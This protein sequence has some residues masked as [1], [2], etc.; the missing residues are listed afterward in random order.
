M[1]P[2]SSNLSRS[3][4][5]L[6]GSTGDSNVC[7]L[8]LRLP[9]FLWL[10]AWRGVVTADPVV[11][12]WRKQFHGD[13]VLQRLGR[14]HQIREN[15]QH[16]P[17]GEDNLVAVDR[18]LYAPFLDHR[19]LFVVVAVFRN[20]APLA[21]FQARD[22]HDFAVNG[23]SRQQSVDLVLLKSIPTIRQ[24]ARVQARTSIGTVYLESPC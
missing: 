4:C 22:R 16:V 14:V 3:Y 2:T 12:A 18:E 6:T 19:D 9:C 10:L 20:H 11:A 15:V 21:H 23:L 8:N 24:I 7:V 13:R 1:Y 17:R 5:S